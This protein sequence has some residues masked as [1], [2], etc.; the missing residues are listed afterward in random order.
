MKRQVIA[1]VVLLAVVGVRPSAPSAVAGS[2]STDAQRE[3]RRAFQAAEAHFR[4]GRFAEALAAYQAGYDASPLPGFLINIAQCQRRLGDL[5]KARATYQK[6]VM[7]APDSPHI[8]EVK[9]LIS[10]LDRLIADL[11]RGDAPA[12]EKSADDDRG[13]A[14]AAPAAATPVPAAV[15]PAA[16]PAA[17]VT[18]APAADDAPPPE[19]SPRHRWWLW[20]LIGVAV[21]G[22]GATAAVFALSPGTTTLHDG[23][24]GT[25]R[26]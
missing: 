14:E 22:A 9:S 16:P 21:L 23:T 1:V 15:P 8:P 4:A 7:V 17:L 18:A 6:Y 11:D 5:R 25:L 2:P 26:R 3:A 10:E 19:A 24:L 12:A 20:G 13:A